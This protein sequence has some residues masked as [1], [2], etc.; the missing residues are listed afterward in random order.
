MIRKA[1]AIGACLLAA[2]GARAPVGPV[3]LAAP[4]GGADDAAPDPG[5]KSEAQ[6]MLDQGDAALNQGDLDKADNAYRTLM[7]SYV[8]SKLAR[9]A[10]VRL[11]DILVKR[12]RY[13]DAAQAYEKF[14]HDHASSD[15]W[16]EVKTKY[17]DARARER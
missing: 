13:D 3:Y 1:T 15:L 14:L 9:V 4:D 12:G 7:R 11:A 2:C 5:Y 16:D 8:Y 6:A 17:E 10:E